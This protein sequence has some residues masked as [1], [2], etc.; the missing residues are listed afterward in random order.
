MWTVAVYDLHL[1]T[2]QFYELTPRQFHLLTE[3]HRRHLS[4]M[5]MIQA[6]TTSAVI[7]TMG[8]PEEP[9]PPTKFMPNWRQPKQA[10]SDTQFKR[11]TL[12]EITDWQARVVNLAAELRQ[13]HGPMLDEIRKQSNA[14]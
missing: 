9:V 14:G 6:Y 8:A 3:A 13:G 10:P 4:H 12:A 11:L 7:N 2:D 1:T 5:E